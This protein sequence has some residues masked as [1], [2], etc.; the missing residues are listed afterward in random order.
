M[1]YVGQV[2]MT[3]ICY[4]L[5]NLYWAVPWDYN[6][7]TQ[8]QR[9][10]IIICIIMTVNS[11]YIRCTIMKGDQKR[12]GFYTRLSLSHLIIIMN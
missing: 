11:L 5:K 7:A 1:S 9:Y 12:N 6:T 4:L 10:I 8:I 3:G 2:S